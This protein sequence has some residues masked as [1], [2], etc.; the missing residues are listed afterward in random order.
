MIFGRSFPHIPSSWVPV[1]IED[2]G[3]QAAGIPAAE[4][5]KAAVQGAADIPAAGDSKAAVQE[6]AGIPAA[7][8][9]KAA[10]Q[11]AADKPAAEDS[12]AA[13]QEAAD[14]PVPAGQAVPEHRIPGQGIGTVLPDFH[15]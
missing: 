14:R 10:V 13:A 6:A 7:G 12:K 15:P 5:S 9:S 11:G 3:Q 8:D 4:D 1:H 2:R